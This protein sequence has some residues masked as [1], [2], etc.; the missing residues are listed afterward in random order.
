M[1]SSWEAINQ[2]LFNV[3]VFLFWRFYVENAYGLDPLK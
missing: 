2:V 3:E 1:A